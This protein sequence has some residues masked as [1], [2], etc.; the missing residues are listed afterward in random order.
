[1]IAVGKEHIDK[2]DLVYSTHL[3]GWNN[4]RWLID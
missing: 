2:R 1:M 3:N 4:L